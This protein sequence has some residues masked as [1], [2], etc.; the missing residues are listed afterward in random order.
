MRRKELRDLRDKLR[1]NLTA[2]ATEE[3]K[4]LYKN[5]EKNLDYLRNTLALKKLRN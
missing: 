3:E 1:I 2:K 4:I 5:L